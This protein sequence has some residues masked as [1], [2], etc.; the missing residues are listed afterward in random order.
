M[1]IGIA[2]RGS[3][4]YGC[5]RAFATQGAELAITHHSEKSRPHV[6]PLARELNVPIF[7]PCDVQ[8]PGELEAVFEAAA[9][10]WGRIDF[11]LHSIAFAPRA[12]L[13]G[14]VVDSSRE[15]F[16]M[17][18]DISC[19]SFARVAKLA[20]PLMP[21]GGT[22]LTVGYEGSRRV[23]PSYGLMGPVKAALESM[24][25]YLA[26]ELGPRSIR[27]HAL[28]PSP[29]RTR[30]ASGLKELEAMV[31]GAEAHKALPALPDIDDVGAT[32]AFLVSDAARRLTG[33]NL[34]IDSGTHLRA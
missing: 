24:V 32:A 15:G 19:H 16:L 29:I 7:R 28:S 31:A 5:A 12:D 9:Q 22:L 10:R 14:R 30:A 27:V 2:N 13:H 11:V 4:A 21:E 18:M 33:L 3:I 8:K 23:I 17:A 25:L 1:V 26:A 34:A 20:E 6:E